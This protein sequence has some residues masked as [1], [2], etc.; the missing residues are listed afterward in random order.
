MTTDLA[1]LGVTDPAVVAFA[2]GIH[3]H[4]RRVLDD[5]ATHDRHFQVMQVLRF[6]TAV[7]IG[8]CHPEVQK[9]LWAMLESQEMRQFVEAVI[10]CMQ[11]PADAR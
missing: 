3:E 10:E 8:C 9:E 1:P 6:E 5:D 2:E 7:V 4:L 11:A